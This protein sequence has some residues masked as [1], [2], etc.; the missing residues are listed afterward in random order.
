MSRGDARGE[1]GIPVRA[2]DGLWRGL[3]AVWVRPL[4]PGDTDTIER[5]FTAMSAESRRM[6]FLAPVPRLTARSLRRL[7][8]VDHDTNGC[9]VAAVRGAPVGLGRYS[10]LPDEA[11]VAEVALEVADEMQGRGVGKLLLA[12]VA[13]AAADV[14][15]RSLVWL[16]DPA[17][18]RV[19]H[20]GL[21]LGA[22][23]RLESGVV[24][25]RV[26][27]PFAEGPY[28]ADVARL[29]RA[30]RVAIAAAHRPDVA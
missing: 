3:P 29:A 15:V 12:T 24:E 21:Q 30:S 13:A 16:M 14:G 23:L 22:A 8:D 25:G 10:R 1:A 2:D 27:I 17:N 5:V 11:D 18:V 9:W 4:R 28:A 19:R 20:L 6:R 7:A 26:R